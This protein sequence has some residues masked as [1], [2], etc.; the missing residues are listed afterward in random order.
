MKS[1]GDAPPNPVS[2]FHHQIKGRGRA[3]E[4]TRSIRVNSLLL[5]MIGLAGWRQAKLQPK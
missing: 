3:I 1:P 5:T 2:A 4:M